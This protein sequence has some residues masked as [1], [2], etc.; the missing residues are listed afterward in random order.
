M[1]A[2]VAI[3]D[4][5]MVETHDC[6]TMAEMIE[7]EAMGLAAPGEGWQ[8][9]REG[10]T[11]M[12]GALPVNPSGGLK[13]RG[14]PIG[15]TGVSQHVMAAM[16]LM[17]EAGAMQVPGAELAGRLQHGRCGGRELRLDPGAGEMSEPAGRLA[18]CTTRVMNLAHFVTQA[19]AARAGRRSRSSGA[20]GCGPGREFDARIDAIAAALQ[21][22]FGAGEGRPGP[23][24]VAE[25]HP[26]VRGDVRLLARR[27]R[28]GS[29]EL[30]PDA[31]R[32]SRI[33]RRLPGRAGHDLQRGLSRSTRR[34]AGCRPT[35]SGD[36]GGGLR[37]AYRRAGRGA[38]WGGRR[39]WRRWVAT[40]PAG[41]S[42]PRARRGGP[43]PRC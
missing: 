32:R 19:R 29:D 23:G 9:I 39:R 2:G 40:I 18:P 38:S 43:R 8:V 30:P 3:G 21:G 31:P 22:R 42:S 34:P 41:S 20:S 15:A 10:T 27:R 14:H 37:A 24:A 13:S 7:Y 26:D 4:L 33:W 16:Q 17:G 5:D 1:Q 12:D 25:L 35:A 6:F 36:R 11:R 28:L